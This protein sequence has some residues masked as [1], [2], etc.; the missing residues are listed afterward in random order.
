MGSNKK[1]MLG[2]V[3]IGSIFKT[4]YKAI[5]TMKGAELVALCSRSEDKL[6]KESQKLGIKAYRTVD[7]MVL[8]PDIDA[9]IVLTPPY[10]HADIG[11]QVV[12]AGKHLLIEKPLDIDEIKAQELLEEAEKNNVIV[13][14]ISQMRFGKAVQKTKK[15]IDS[16][17][18][19]KLVLLRVSMKWNRSKNYYNSTSWVTD[20]Q[21][22]GGGVLINQGIHFLDLL[23]WL[24]GPY[25]DVSSF[26]ETFKYDL[27]I[28]DTFVGTIKFNNNALGV[29]EATTATCR[30]LPNVIEVHGTKGSIVIQNNK[31]V[32]FHFGEYSFTNALK[33]KMYSKLMSFI[34]LK[35]GHIA[36]Q[37]T[38]F[39]STIQN[40]GKVFI[41]GSEGL[42]TLKLCR[43]LYQNVK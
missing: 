23:R 41:P 15:L 39:V 9:I 7:E 33:S 20:P 26:K 4:H 11:L 18:L 8:N 12:R 17:K 34:P 6:H 27:P 10:A 43:K 21:K 2:V 14:V 5:T 3:G 32:E 22:S 38:N 25:K 36:D 37:I 29:I 30:N 35:K 13:S 16:G 42:D 31:F 40:G 1:I 19:G 24:G 28:E